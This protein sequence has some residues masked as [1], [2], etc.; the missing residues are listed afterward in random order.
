MKHDFN[1]GDHCLYCGESWINT[2]DPETAMP[3][4]CKIGPDGLEEIERQAIIIAKVIKL[5]KKL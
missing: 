5:I 2:R 4:P 3:Q 1:Q